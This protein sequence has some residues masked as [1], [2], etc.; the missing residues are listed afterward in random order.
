MR[1]LR[2]L[3]DSDWASSLTTNGEADPIVV[4]MTDTDVE[5]A[6]NTVDD[7]DVKG[8]TDP[9]VFDRTDTDVDGATNTVDDFI[10]RAACMLLMTL[11]AI[12][13]LPRAAFWP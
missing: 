8:E 11:A 9:M 10:V 6:T 12:V 1:R 3:E 7:V 5:G 4:D 2:A 13:A